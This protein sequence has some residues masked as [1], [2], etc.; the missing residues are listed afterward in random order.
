MAVLLKNVLLNTSR[1]VYN[2][3]TGGTAAPTAYLTAVEAHGQPTTTRS[4][5]QHGQAVVSSEYEFSVDTGVDVA[6]EDIITSIMQL[7]GVT[8]WPGDRASNDTNVTWRVSYIAEAAALLLPHRTVYVV[9]V[10]KGGTA[11]P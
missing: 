10:E 1:S 8:P 6:I 9:R 11:H 3:S 5:I 2:G 7:D 4:L